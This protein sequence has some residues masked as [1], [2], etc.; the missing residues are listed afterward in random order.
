MSGSPVLAALVPVDVRHGVVRAVLVRPPGHGEALGAVAPEVAE[1][2]AV[3]PVLEA[4]MV[5]DLMTQPAGLLEEDAHE[6]AA[7]APR[8]EMIVSVVGMGRHEPSTEEADHERRRHL[9]DVV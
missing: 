6:H 5:A 9:V 2:L 1:E 4:L 7:P 8:R 3:D